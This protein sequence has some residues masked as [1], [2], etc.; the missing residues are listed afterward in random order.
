MQKNVF[1]TE[2]L[3][4]IS[5]S[6][7]FLLIV[8][9]ATLVFL[10][11]TTYIQTRITGFITKELSE[12]IQAEIN[13]QN[14]KLSLFKG[15]VFKGLNIKDQQN[16]TLLYIKEFSLIPDGLQ[17]DF[18]NINLKKIEFDDLYL[19]IY[20][21]QKDSL[22]IDYILNSFKSDDEKDTTSV[23]NIHTNSLRLNNASLK[24]SLIDTTEKEGFNSKD[25]ALS[26][27]NLIFED[28]AVN[29]DIINVQVKEISFKDKSGFNLNKLSID[30]FLIHPRKTKLTNLN[31]QTEKSNLGFDSLK[32]DYPANFE[33][34]DFLNTA[35]I[36]LSINKSSRLS[37]DDVKYFISDTSDYSDFINISGIISGKFDDINISDLYIN[38]ED[39]L[40]LKLDA[41]IK[42]LSNFEDPSFVLDIKDLSTDI[43]KL[44]EMKIP[45]KEKVLEVLPEELKAVKYLTYKGVSKGKLS[46]FITDADISGNFGTIK[47]NAITKK[48]SARILN[49]DGK[50]SGKELK[51]AEVVKN[52]S[53]G[54]LSFNQE[55]D[56]SYYRNK[57]IGLTTFGK[58]DEITYKNFVY[59]NVDLFAELKDKK[60]DSLSINLNQNDVV[61]KLY[62]NVN[63]IPDVPE[64][65]LTADVEKANLKKMNLDKAKES[66]VIS[67]KLDAFFNG[68]NIDDFVGT[69]SLTEPLN[70]QKDTV[71][72][73]VNNLMLSSFMTR[74]DSLNIKEIN[75]QSDIAD[76]IIKS[77]GKSSE[78]FRSL[79]DHLTTLFKSDELVD[80]SESADQVGYFDIEGN[81]KKTDDISALF[82]PHIKIAQ[83]TKIYGYFDNQK[84]RINMSLNSVNFK[85]GNIVVND[86]YLIAYTRNNQ[87]YAGLGGS[88]LSPG[89][90]FF[91]E[92]V[93]LEGDV[94]NDTINFNLI[95]NNFK[96]S[97]NYSADISGHVNIKKQEERSIYECTFSNSEIVM[98]DSTWFFS[99]SIVTLD[100]SFINIADLTIKNNS[101]EI[102]IDGNISKYPGDILYTEFRN[103]N[104]INLKPLIPEDLKIEGELNGSTTIAQLYDDPLIFTSDSIVK[105]HIN[106]IDFGNL[107][108]KSYWDNVGNKIHANAYNLKGSRRQFMNDTIYGDYWP[109]KD[110]IDFTIDIRSMTLQAFEQYYSDYLE[111]NKT[112]YITGIVDIEGNIKDPDFSGDLKLKQT[113][114][115]VKSLNTVNNIEEMNIHIDD[116]IISFSD[117][118][119][120]SGN[121]Q[122][123]ALI[124]G[125][126]E[127]HNFSDFVF[128]I[129][130]DADNYML[131][132]LEYTDSSYFYG[133]AIA[134][135]NMNI[136][137][138]TDDIVLDANIV[139]EKNT[140]ISIPISSSE[141]LKEEASFIQFVIDTTIEEN[142]NIQE[143]FETDLSGFSMNV[144][145]DVTPD[146]QIQIIPDESTGD[147]ITRGEGELNL[148]LDREGEF[149][150]FGIY[151][152]SEGE[153]KF[154]LIELR[155]DFNIQEGGTIEWY[156][157]P[158]DGTINLT[159]VHSLSGVSVKQFLPPD[160]PARRSDVDCIIELSG[161]LLNPDLKLDVKVPET[162]DQTVTSAINSMPDN[163]KNRHFLSL[164]L[165]K[166]F[167]PTAAE[168]GFEFQTEEILAEQLNSIISGLGDVDVGVKYQTDKEQGT[169]EYGVQISETFWDDRIEVKG[170]VG[171]ET[172]ENADRNYVGEFELEA[173][174][175]KKGTLRAKA[176]NKANDDIQ[177]EGEYVQG[178]GFVWRKK[179]DS[180]LFW[181][182]KEEFDSIKVKKEKTDTFKIKKSPKK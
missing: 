60:I 46:G 105:L 102:Y 81:I 116:K 6:G 181:K 140:S 146:A 26:D 80:E 144:K 175:N 18:E 136:T 14:V 137:G 123:S 145:L 169:N 67:M 17:I 1:H 172:K 157:D 159:A 51:I 170:N 180:F 82:F 94:R 27:M 111:F 176:Y 162:E 151:M 38:N 11:H 42:E 2:K 165:I 148:T 68:I 85:Y 84:S 97:A 113:T 132:N 74:G 32:V 178:V 72:I 73:R 44:R 133:K 110:S 100:S 120:I 29:N 179:F 61:A 166:S 150:M 104:L 108:F 131:M 156:G 78:I 52:N 141:T 126:I 90:S 45:G 112:A 96:D 117:T 33:F 30:N 171:V 24:Y 173:K 107:Y 182:K 163:E 53:L 70:Y 93:N 56:F 63:F 8:L 62:G 124:K 83:D 64:F 4:K 89:E 118:R 57:K 119:L 7:I 58:I 168:T 40:S 20:E 21:I 76:L 86:F 69:I 128:N 95:W 55:F 34:S 149:N 16:D 87:L 91:V 130:I 142:K 25:I 71:S 3:R 88:S 47:V 106:D 122:S 19:N 31:I 154:R 65:N 125:N 28:L 161:K 35:G 152:I 109:D 66:S 160:E 10:L 77:S 59:S 41:K 92:N 79:Q 13:I 99:E 22:N 48:D 139:T 147:I 121:Q 37:Y 167:D 155:K 36:Y 9:V 158:A 127:H 50:I 54:L 164:L 115:V 135:G 39:V 138:P 23:L 49:I 174:L 101:E 129:E 5:L 98:N 12:K 103:F 177:M 153:Y 134:S 43:E 15:F 114:A 143:T 75:L